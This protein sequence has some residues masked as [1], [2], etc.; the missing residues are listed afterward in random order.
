[1]QAT[2]PSSTTDNAIKLLG[3]VFV[4]GASLLM[5]GKVAAG[6]V[7]TIIGTWARVAL[8]PVGL[9]LVIANSYSNSATGKNLIKQFTG[10]RDDDKTDAHKSDANKTDANKTEAKASKAKS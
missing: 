5:D 6:A 9:A 10:N 1:M 8:G 4:P 3:E 2:K 7:H